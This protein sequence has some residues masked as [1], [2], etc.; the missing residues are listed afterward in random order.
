MLQK[1]MH[2]NA[3]VYRNEDLLAEGCSKMSELTKNINENI[4]VICHS[5]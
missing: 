2:N 5:T 4:Q 1:V 3:G